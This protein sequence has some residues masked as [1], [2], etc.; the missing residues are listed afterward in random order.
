M[1]PSFIRKIMANRSFNR[2]QK[3]LN[4]L[5]KL[6]CNTTKLLSSK[7]LNLINIFNNEEILNSWKHWQD[8]FDSLNIPDLTEGVNPGD[9]KAIFFLIRHFKP[10]S[11]LEIGT[12]IGASTVNIASALNY[13]QTELQIKPAFRT[14]DIRDVNSVS[15]KPW[16]QYGTDRSPLEIIKNFELDSFVEFITDTSLNYFE[17]TT[18]T[19]DFIFLDGD[20]IATTVY[21]EIPMALEKLNNGGIILLHDYF[22]NGKPLWSNKSELCG[23]FLATER[24]IKEGSD[25][26]ILPLGNLPWKTKLNSNVTSLALCLKN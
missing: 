22:P 11:V 17:K 20:H 15:E 2:M 25:I 6:Q 10:E 12:H 1:R 21:Q 9:R 5:K 7:E 24:L 13:N 19:F 16:I 18:E 8:K 26:V 14:I 4:A 23:P 3:Q